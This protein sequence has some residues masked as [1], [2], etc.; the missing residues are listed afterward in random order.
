MTPNKLPLIILS[1]PSGAGKDTVAANII[2][3]RL[4]P[5]EKVITSTTRAPR[6]NN[7]KPELDG[8][9][10]DFYKDPEEFQTR[11]RE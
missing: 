7:G 3:N 5:I 8:V 11:V 2:N 4:A 9:H 10:Y 6:E 1:G